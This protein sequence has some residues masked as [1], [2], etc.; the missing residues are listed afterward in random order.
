MKPQAHSITQVFILKMK[1]SIPWIMQWR[2]YQPLIH[3]YY[4]PHWW[5]PSGE[6]F[7]STRH[8]HSL[9]SATSPLNVNFNRLWDAWPGFKGSTLAHGD[10]WGVTPNAVSG[11]WLQGLA[12][13]LAGPAASLAGHV[14]PPP[15]WWE[16]RNAEWIPSG[17]APSVL[18]RVWA[19]SRV[20]EGIGWLK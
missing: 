20:K 15:P 18:H 17:T 1:R 6:L 12:A 3:S 4:L 9:S 7:I 8:L 2:Q 10:N 13:V 19:L 16:A 14:A 11:V 5:R